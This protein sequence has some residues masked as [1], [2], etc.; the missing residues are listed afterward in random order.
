MA[1]ATVLINKLSINKN[2]DLECLL[3]GIF[4]FC[5]CRG[6]LK[7]HRVSVPKQFDYKVFASG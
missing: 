5:L 2:A 7:K 6:V 3:K 1:S 4:T